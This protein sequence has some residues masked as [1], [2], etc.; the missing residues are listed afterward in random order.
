MDLWNKPLKWK[1]YSYPL[2]TYKYLYSKAKAIFHDLKHIAKKEEQKLS[3]VIESVRIKL[4][5]IV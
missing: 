5:I 4:I 3:Y 2:L 1:G